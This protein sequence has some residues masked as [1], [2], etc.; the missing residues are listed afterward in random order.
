MNKKYIYSLLAS[1]LLI[2]QTSFSQTNADTVDL[3]EVILSLPFDQDKGKSVIKVE[4]I[5]LNNINPILISITLDISTSLKV[6]NR[7]AFS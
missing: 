3:D 1:M 4:K 7:A 6:V 2:S 5:N